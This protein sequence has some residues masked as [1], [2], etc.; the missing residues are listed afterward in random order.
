MHITSTHSSKSI[1]WSR[2]TYGICGHHGSPYSA[3]LCGFSSMNVY[4]DRGSLTFLRGLT[5]N[6]RAS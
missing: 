6:C 2:S 3:V 4:V 1:H 5:R